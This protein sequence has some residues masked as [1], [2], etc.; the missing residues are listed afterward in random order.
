MAAATPSTRA[1][2][3]T[4]VVSRNRFSSLSSGG[5]RPSVARRPP[6][7]LE[8]VS[9]RKYRTTFLQQG[10]PAFPVDDLERTHCPIAGGVSSARRLSYDAPV[11][12]QLNNRLARTADKD[13]RM[14]HVCVCA[15]AEIPGALDATLVLPFL[16]RLL[17]A[18]Q[19]F[20]EPSILPRDSLA[21]RFERSSH[22]V[23]FELLLDLAATQA[24]H[25]ALTREVLKIAAIAPVAP[26]PRQSSVGTGMP[27]ADDEPVQLVEDADGGGRRLLELIKRRLSSDHEL[28]AVRLVAS[29]DV[30]LRVDGDDVR[31]ENERLRSEA[32]DAR[33]DAEDAR[34][35]ERRLR[36]D[37][38]AAERRREE[39]LEA[40]ERESA[41]AI[42]G[43][44]AKLR[45]SDDAA[46]ALRQERDELKKRR[47]SDDGTVDLCGDDDD[48]PPPK[49]KRDA[50]RE[51]YDDQQRKLVAKVKIEKGEALEDFKDAEETLGYQVRTT[52][53]LQGK[54]DELVNLCGEAERLA[55]LAAEAATAG[56]C[57]AAGRLAGEARE[58][59]DSLKVHSIKYRTNR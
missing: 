29:I 9:E 55:N 49:R 47:E 40:A 19:R 53:C 1:H 51:I 56:D 59:V 38:E 17:A 12:A 7:P 54:I 27:W 22:V 28:S 35:A 48:A 37:L 11:V 20:T 58:A 8:P 42:G 23:A 15:L 52:D 2:G 31:A 4:N 32:D 57:D 26:P 5:S 6:K 14:R 36:D 41:A 39:D 25:R 3:V 21:G 50:L 24:G 10:A 30:A 43:M 18:R 33:A 46:E 34:A 16:V 13:V 44:A 45:E